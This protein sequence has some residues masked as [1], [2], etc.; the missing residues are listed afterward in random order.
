[1]ER[2]VN[3]GC[4]VLKL[5][6]S[7]PNTGGIQLRVTVWAAVEEQF[8]WMR[9][10]NTEGKGSDTASRSQGPNLRKR[11][12]WL[13]FST[14]ERRVLAKSS[15]SATALVT[16]MS[17]IIASVFSGSLRWRFWI[18]WGE[19][20]HQFC[21]ATV[22]IPGS[23]SAKWTASVLQNPKETLTDAP[24][25]RGALTCSLQILFAKPL[26]QNPLSL[27]ISSIDFMESQI[28]SVY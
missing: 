27:P 23:R 17:H 16:R 7:C 9:T 13:I 2:R 28:R 21:E 12:L 24:E 1:M 11:Q 6:P 25:G 3:D 4:P 26:D 8:L 15:V 5:V 20:L 14:S 18:S 19:R 10:V 22:V